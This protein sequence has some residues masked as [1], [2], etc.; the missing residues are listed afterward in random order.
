MSETQNPKPYDL[1]ERTKK[2][3]KRT[4]D[5]VEI[6]PKTLANMEDARQLIKSSGSVGANYIEAE[7]SLS[8]KDFAMRI[9]ICRKEA[10]ESRYW[11]E[12]TEPKEDQTEEQKVLIQEA[13]ELT[14]IFGSIVEKSK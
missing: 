6:L 3:A 9:K 7:E 11:F 10:K 2:F 12:L 13:T 5:Y 1:G 14:K 8:K 4:R